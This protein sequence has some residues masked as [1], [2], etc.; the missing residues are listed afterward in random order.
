M[1]FLRNFS[2]KYQPK[3]RNGVSSLR[4]KGSNFIKSE[5]SW[6]NFALLFLLALGT[7]VAIKS[8]ANN[9]LTMGYNDYRLTKGETIDLSALQKELIKN[10]G[11]NATKA[12][13]AADGEMC[14]E[15]T[16]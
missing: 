4:K 2:H 14:E 13:D 6:R 7:G 11:N 12:R 5:H 10:G 16:E 1:D 3:L 9:S 15:V 8:L